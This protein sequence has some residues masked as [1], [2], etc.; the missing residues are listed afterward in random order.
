MNIR[1]RKTWSE[2]ELQILRA[3]YATTETATLAAELGRTA[4][5]VNGKAFLLGLNKCKQE[6]KSSSFAMSERALR[7]MHKWT[8][9][10]PFADLRAMRLVCPLGSDV[11]D[12]VTNTRNATRKGSGVDSSMQWQR[13]RSRMLWVGPKPVLVISYSDGAKWLRQVST[14]MPDGMEF[15]LMRQACWRMSNRVSRGSRDRTA[16]AKRALACYRLMWPDDAR[17]R[18]QPGEAIRAFESVAESGNRSD[19]L[20]LHAVEES[21]S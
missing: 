15:G 13:L 5:S 20:A 17:L 12:G 9:D 19:L 18:R 7:Q 4:H 6:F 21:A 16:L 1:P 3:R 2:P 10:E 11:W 8:P 14:L